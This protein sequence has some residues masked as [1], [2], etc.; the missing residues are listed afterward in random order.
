M[1]S[2]H[3]I[4]CKLSDSE[5]D[6]IGEKMN[7]EVTKLNAQMLSIAR[8]KLLSHF[9]PHCDHLRSQLCYFDIHLLADIVH[10]TVR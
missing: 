9:N 2:S 8:L 3:K 7:I 5:M 1:L 4:D 10:L 6:D